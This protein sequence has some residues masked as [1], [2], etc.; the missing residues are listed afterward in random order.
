VLKQNEKVAFIRR[1]FEMKAE[2]RGHKEISHYLRQYGDI[3]IGSK[4]LT[5][6]L[7]TNTVYIGEYTEK[8]TGQNFKNLLFMEGKPP[9]Y[10]FPSGIRSNIPSQ[11]REESTGVRK[12]KML[13]KKEEG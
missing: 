9:L 2:R 4:E 13:L 1:A 6:R 12:I 11:R 8:N 5:D 10:Y 3:K 7:F